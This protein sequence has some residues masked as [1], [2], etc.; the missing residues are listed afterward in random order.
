LAAETLQQLQH[1]TP[2]HTM[3][4]F[5]KWT[6]AQ[7]ASSERFARSGDAESEA[8]LAE[9]RKRRASGSNDGSEQRVATLISN[10]RR[11]SKRRTS[12]ARR[13]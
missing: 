10:N 7:L 12:A 9:L 1:S 8:M 11:S 2:Q 3:I 5:T 4:D 13:R 6:D